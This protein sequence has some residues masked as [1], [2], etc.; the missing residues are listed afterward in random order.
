MIIDKTK[1][2]TFYNNIGGE[3]K[4][5]LY[6]SIVSH[7][8]GRDTP[9]GFIISRSGGFVGYIREVTNNKDPT[10]EISLIC[11]DATYERLTGSIG[12][13]TEKTMLTI[14]ER[15]GHYYHLYHNK[16]FISV[17]HYISHPQQ[18]EIINQIKVIYQTKSRAVSFIYGGPGI[19]KSTIGLLLAKELGGSLCKTF[20]PTD[21]GDN[22]SLL[23]NNANPK[24]DN[25]LIV[26]M[27]E[28]DIMINRIH[29]GVVQTHKDIPVCI[30][31]KSSW[32][33]FFD[34][35]IFYENII[36]V[37]TSN[38]P[39]EWIDALDSSYL[40]TGRI[41]ANFVLNA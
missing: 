26:L 34:D 18:T 5:A 40:R 14:Y 12:K 8:N 2:A 33:S 25:P 36:I 21:P 41:D 9:F 35:M 1:V 4:T 27:D 13:S 22:I 37:M 11:T 39:K 23:I 15:M 29:T 19:G 24:K 38:R 31:D 7:A 20:K 32:N 6:S 30:L 17:D 28:I 16:L 10:T 3:G